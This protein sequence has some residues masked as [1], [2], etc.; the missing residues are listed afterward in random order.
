MG[1]SLR[2]KNM[3]CFVFTSF[4]TWTFISKTILEGF[5]F[6]DH[7]WKW[8]KVN[9]YLISSQ[10]DFKI[11]AIFQ[12]G[13]CKRRLSWKESRINEF[14][15]KQLFRKKNICWFSNFLFEVTLEVSHFLN[16]H[17]LFLFCENMHTKMYFITIFWT[18]AAELNWSK[19]SFVHWWNEVSIK[20]SSVAM[21]YFE[22]I[23]KVHKSIAKSTF[24]R[25]FNSS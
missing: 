23:K 21:V 1:E 12:R 13:L 10:N 20:Y 25:F 3:K 9:F 15:R 2:D 6:F 18:P 4:F 22:I 14:S 16:S 19:S 17:Y 5:A 11:G 24:C 7:R 8:S